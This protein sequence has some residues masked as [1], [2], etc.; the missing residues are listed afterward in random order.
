MEQNLPT[1]IGKRR[2]DMIIYIQI[3]LGLLVGGAGFRQIAESPLQGIC[4]LFLAG[5]LI[6]TGLEKML[7]RDPHK[8]EIEPN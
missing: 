2:P 8:S 7:F 1:V 3:I 4:A 6:M 5:F